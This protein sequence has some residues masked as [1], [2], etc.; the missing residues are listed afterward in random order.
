MG[1]TLAPTA[2][3]ATGGAGSGGTVGGALETGDVGVGDAPRPA[4]Q[5]WQRLARAEFEWPQAAQVARFKGGKR[6]VL[7]TQRTARPT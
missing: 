2:G 3:L 4:P 7:S 1:E 6:R 5:C